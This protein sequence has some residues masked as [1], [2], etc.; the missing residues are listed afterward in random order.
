FDDFGLDGIDS[1]PQLSAGGYDRGEG[2]GCWDTTR[3][4]ANV[5]AH[6]RQAIQ[7]MTDDQLAN[8]SVF[9]D[10]GIR[11]LL[12]SLVAMHGLAGDLQ[13]RGR[14]VHIYDGH[15]ALNYS[16]HTE[17]L[18]FDAVGTVWNETGDNVL[19]RYGQPDADLMTKVNGDGGHVGTAEQ[20][21]DRV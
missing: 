5:V 6:S 9:F 4:Y 19:V 17:D 10:G 1:T 13:A 21:L 18:D 14:Y 20:A 3:G 16:G 8:I 7:H 11:D 2:N 15:P 12:N